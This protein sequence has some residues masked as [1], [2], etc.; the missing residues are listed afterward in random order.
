[1]ILASALAVPVLSLVPLPVVA[2]VFLYLGNK[3]MGGNQFLRR[4]KQLF[5]DEKE[6]SVTT[7]GEK[8]QVILGRKA[9]LRF[10]ALQ[11]L[12][13]AALWALK[14]S[15]S[16]ALIFPAVIGVLMLLRAKLI[17][18]L[19]STR[20]LMLLDTAPARIPRREP[21]VARGRAHA[22][23][24]ERAA[25]GEAAPVARAVGTVRG[26]PRGAS[27]VSVWVGGGWRR[28]RSARPRP[29]DAWRGRKKDLGGPPG[30]GPR[31]LVGYL[32]HTFILRI[33]CSTAAECDHTPCPTCTSASVRLPATGPFTAL[34]RGASPTSGR[35]HRA[36][37]SPTCRGCRDLY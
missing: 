28:A 16:T 27:I 31:A 1:M 21:W 10:T 17:P 7:V 35:K 15:P 33:S 14:L 37:G 4:C 5:L 2:G 30:R 19:F 12:C 29:S 32:C 20:E 9:V 18:R 6:L 13:L 11:C 24:G 8:E 34:K 25:R 3:V 23:A 22:A 26:V 36:R